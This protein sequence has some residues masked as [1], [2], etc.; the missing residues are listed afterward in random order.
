MGNLIQS[1]MIKGRRSFGRKSLVLFPLLVVLMAIMLMGGSLTQ[2]GAY[3]WWCM[4]FLP[5]VVALVCINLIGAEKKMHFFN[6]EV[7]PEAK[8]KVWVAKVCV[9]CFYIFIANFIVFGLTSISGFFF[10]AQYPA[11]R[12]FVAAMILTVSYAWQIPLGMLLSVKLNSAAIFL[13]V[14]STNIICSLQDIAG[15]RFWFIPFAIPARLMSPI[16]GINPNGVPLAAGS[17][18]LDSGVILPGM[19]IAA[20]L[21]VLALTLT[22]IW[23]EKRGE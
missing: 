18:L 11:W 9:G 6:T 3:N 13:L 1:E 21:F 14:L 12:G 2:I 15:G 8:S 17:P 5:T 7:L 10:G 16:L 4:I 20:A 22:S 19:L 23:F